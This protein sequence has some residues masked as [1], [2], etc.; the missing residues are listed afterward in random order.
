MILFI[1][2]QIYGW[3]PKPYTNSSDLPENAPAALRKQIQVKL[4]HIRQV[5][6][7]LMDP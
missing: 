1:S 6:L 3:L 5:V 4:T 7:L 2:L